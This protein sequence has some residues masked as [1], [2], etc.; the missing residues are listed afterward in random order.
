MGSI[1]QGTGW[2]IKK[3]EAFT[4]AFSRLKQKVLW[5]Y[6]NDS[7]PNK[8]DNVMIIPWLPQRDVLAH[9]NVKLFITHG[10]LLGVSES[11]SEGVPILGIPI[12]SD[13]TMNILKAIDD[14]YG[15]L[16]NYDDVEENLIVSNI[17]EMLVNPKYRENAKEVSSRYL[18]RP[19]SP[20]QTTTYWVEYL[21]RHKGAPQFQSAAHKLNFIQRNLIDSYALLA[22]IVASI[23]YFFYRLKCALF[24]AKN[25]LKNRAKLKNH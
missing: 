24:S 21:I 2:E 23:F 14:G 4:R 3:R 9:P 17:Q 25:H 13:Q 10:G 5:K 16:M 8:S 19:M 1:L 6:E 15:M 20:Q 12:Y 7:L 18:D 22:L 11:I